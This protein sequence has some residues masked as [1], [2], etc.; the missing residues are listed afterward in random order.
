MIQTSNNMD[1][2]SK[3]WHVISVDHHVLKK[4]FIQ[5]HMYP[6]LLCIYMWK[7]GSNSSIKMKT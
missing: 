5:N 7:R 1:V 2:L 6:V 3:L 4:I